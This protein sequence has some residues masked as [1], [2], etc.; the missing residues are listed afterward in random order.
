[1]KTKTKKPFLVVGK[2]GTGVT[3]KAKALIGCKEYR[4]FYANDIPISD[5]YSWPLE[6]GIIIED[7]HYKPD[8]DKILD[9]IYS[10]RNVVLTSKNKK[11]VS[12]VIIDCCQVKM[13]GRKNYNQ[14]ILRAKAKNS[15]DFKVV[16]D[17]I[18]AMTNA[19][20]RMPDRDEYLSVLKTYQPPPMQIL[21][22]VVASQPKNQKLMH[23]SKAMMNGGDYFYPL[24][25]YSK[26]G[27]YGSVVPPKRKSVSPFPDICRKLGLRSS[28]GYLVKDL[29]KDEEYSRWAAKKLDEKECKI[30]GIK[31]EKR[32]RVS[33]RKDRT[34]KLEDF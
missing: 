16:D 32:R 30:L 31:K 9:L 1:M 26:L 3:T 33:V 25:A 14:I 22:W 10:G 17:N 5:V 8:K 21:S 20:I 2:S 6:I 15:Q 4:I 34:K 24:L 19:Y 27:T 18:W 29:L 7:V 13:A 28:D 23:V 12:K 11:D